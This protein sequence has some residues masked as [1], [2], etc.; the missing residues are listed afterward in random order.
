MVA[1]TNFDLWNLAVALVA[2]AISAFAFFRDKFYFRGASVT[3]ANQADRQHSMV[4]A[5]GKM[6]PSVRELFPQYPDEMITALVRVVWL[7]T[8]DRATYVH[9]K[10]IIVH[11]GEIKYPCG[12]YS[13]IDVPATG[14][15][16]QPVLVREVPAT[17]NIC[18]TLEIHF[19]WPSI[20]PI[21]HTMKEDVGRVS[22]QLVMA[23]KA[24]S[25]V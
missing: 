18:I 1:A 4:C 16:L 3:L 19:E 2:V 6:P 10:K 14:A 17:A 12:F 15:A 24:T 21:S 9:V 13:Y 8:G 7:N 11:D 25:D 20:R 5:F 22:V 23:G